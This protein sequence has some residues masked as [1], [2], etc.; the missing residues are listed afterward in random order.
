MGPTAEAR[1]LSMQPR[2]KKVSGVHKGAAGREGGGGLS[3]LEVAVA[4]VLHGFLVG[5][6][7]RIH[8]DG[9][10]ALDLHCLVFVRR[11]VNLRPGMRG[12]RCCSQPI[13]R[14]PT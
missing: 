2:C 6:A 12:L 7:G 11:A 1:G 8:E 5:R 10:E 3:C 9:G 13:S 4:L 14:S